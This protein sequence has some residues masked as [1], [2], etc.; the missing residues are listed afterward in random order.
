MQE[1]KNI[2]EFDEIIAHDKV[3]VYFYAP[4]NNSSL[5][6]GEILEEEKDNL[7]E[8]EMVKVNLD[9]ILSL[10]RI[11]HITT[12]PDIKIFERGKI[13]KDILGI[14]TKN[15]LFKELNK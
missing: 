4:W 1:I 10:T 7:S 11:Y 13:T 3:L 14:K 9:R 5:S 12:V 6:V 15:E 2:R 8:Y